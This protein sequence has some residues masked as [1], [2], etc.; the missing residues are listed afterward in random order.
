MHVAS[1]Y[2]PR[3]WHPPYHPVT[4]KLERLL[5]AALE[6]GWQ[7]GIDDLRVLDYL[8]LCEELQAQ[9]PTTENLSRALQESPQLLYPRLL[10]LEEF[11]LVRSQ[12][13]TGVPRWRVSRQG[14][15][16]LVDVGDVGAIGERL[17]PSSLTG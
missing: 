16:L 10:G 9:S 6:Q 14:A 11:G 17:R 1:G 3:M 8:Q 2:L 5:A 4:D 12:M 15:S 13:V 7:L